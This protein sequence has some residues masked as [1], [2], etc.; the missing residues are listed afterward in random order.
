MAERGFPARTG[1]PTGLSPV[2][3]GWPSRLRPAPGAPRR[4][5]LR[6]YFPMESLTAFHSPLAFGGGAAGEDAGYLF[7]Q[8][9]GI[10]R[11]E[12]IGF[13]NAAF[14]VRMIDRDLANNIIITNHYSRRVYRA[15]TLHLGVFIEGH[16]LGVLQYGY[17]MNPASAGSVVTGTA[18]N[19]YL[20]LNRM[21]LDDRAPRFS[22]SQA[23]SCSIRLI[24]RVRPAVKWIQSFADERCG[25]FGT[26]YQAAGFTY[27]GEHRG[28]F[29]ELD[30]EFYHNS[31]MTNAKTAK[32]PRAAHLRANR[33]RATRH[34]LRQFRYLRFLKPRF[35]KGCRYPALPF[36]KPDYGR[37]N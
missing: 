14:Y 10:D 30:G 31:L 19:E 24:R 33:D 2:T 29:W 16:L 17:A 26:V 18:M 28:I 9:L 11:R 7:D 13:G 35:G 21:W 5:F 32:S 23:L 25:L 12:A 6:A 4:G 27:H 15:S 8:R 1:K 3:R 22:E 20:E 36:P 34:A 37:G